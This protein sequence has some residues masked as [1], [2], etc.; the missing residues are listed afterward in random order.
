[1]IGQVKYSWINFR[2]SFTT[3]LTQYGNLILSY[4]LVGISI[5]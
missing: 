2:R 4:I 1:M 3:S 5:T